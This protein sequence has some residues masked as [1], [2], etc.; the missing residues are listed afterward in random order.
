M[1]ANDQPSLADQVR[2][3]R[4]RHGW[5]LQHMS[6]KTGIPLSTLSKVEH[7]QLSLSYEKLLQLCRGLGIQVSELFY[8]PAP[9]PPPRVMA[10][11]SL[12]SADRALRVSAGRHEYFYLC[13][14][15]LNKRMTPLL[16]TIRVQDTN[17]DWPLQPRTGEEFVHVLEGRL[18]VR[19]EF[20]GPMI[21]EAGQS[22]YLDAD[23]AHTYVPAEGCKEARVLAVCAGA[24]D[25]GDGMPQP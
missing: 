8:G 25:G 4:A 12:G 13:T 19:S 7:G 22:I 6:A 24:F 1:Q 15:L 3:L 21:L 17:G 16:A 18:E 14:D 11:R 20:Y 10:R 5:T 23:M 9:L 2:D